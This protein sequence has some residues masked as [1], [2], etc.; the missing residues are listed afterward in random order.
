V[1]VDIELLT[2][3]IAE[4]TERPSWWRRLLRHE[5]ETTRVAVRGAA[6]TWTWDG[7]GRLVSSELHVRLETA[8]GR[9][10][11]WLPREAIT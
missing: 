4:V 8:R 10:I 7:D 5:R 3:S 6:A 9:R 2:L 11:V 1:T